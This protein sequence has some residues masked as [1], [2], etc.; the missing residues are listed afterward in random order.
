MFVSFAEGGSFQTATSLPAAMGATRAARQ[1]IALD[2]GTRRPRPQLVGVTHLPSRA[3]PFCVPPQSV[4]V[5][6]GL[7]QQGRRQGLVNRRLYAHLLASEGP[8]E[9]TDAWV[10]STEKLL[11]EGGKKV[12]HRLADEIGRLRK[13]LRLITIVGKQ[14]FRTEE[15]LERLQSRQTLHIPAGVPSDGGL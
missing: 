7:P 2:S 6:L 3:A 11:T 12:L 9:F 8:R 10:G 4:A 1:P 14:Q 13:D 5:A 15:V